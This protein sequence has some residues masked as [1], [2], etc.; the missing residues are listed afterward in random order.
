MVMITRSAYRKACESTNS[1]DI[2][3]NNVIPPWCSSGKVSERRAKK[4]P[5]WE[6]RSSYPV[7]ENIW[8]YLHAD[9]QRV[10]SKR[11]RSHCNCKQKT[12]RTNGKNAAI[13]FAFLIIALAL[14]GS[15]WM[16]NIPKLNRLTKVIQGDKLVSLWGVSKQT[17]ISEEC[18]N[19]MRFL[20]EE[21][22]KMQQALRHKLRVSRSLLISTQITRTD[23][24]EVDRKYIEGVSVSKGSN[25]EEYGS[26]VAL[27]GV[28][29]L[30][31][32]APPPDLVLTRRNPTPSDCW[33][34]SGSYGEIVME[35]PQALQVNYMSVEHIRP[36]TAR[37]APKR[38]ILSGV[39]ENGTLVNAVDGEYQNRGPA[40]Q[41]YRCNWGK[42]L[43][44]L[45]FRVLSNQGNPTY[46]CVY[47]IHLY[48][49]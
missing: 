21:V 23:K 41:Y 40:K 28:V 7:R 27:W 18:C 15:I 19:R 33:P 5:A 49:K 34:F 22:S 10:I 36:D 38:F 8:Q 12:K 42:P 20:L 2:S 25:T 13:L 9:A 45:I 35:L 24:T 39:L 1:S 17:E 46:T 29:P 31:K 44:R 48:R 4:V 30:W 6:I 37:S 3:Q 11:K 47:R 14:M 43:K 16:T 26:Q 32:A